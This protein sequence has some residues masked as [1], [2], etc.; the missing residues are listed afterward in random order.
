M[1][2]LAYW[3]GYSFMVVGGLLTA[4]AVL[5]VMAWG[6]FEIIAKRVGLTKIIFEWYREKMIGRR[7]G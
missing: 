2:Q 3:I 7:G 5:A 4:A 1:D 6:A